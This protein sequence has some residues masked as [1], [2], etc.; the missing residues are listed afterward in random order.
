MDVEIERQIDAFGRTIDTRTSPPKAFA[1]SSDSF[2]FPTD[3]DP[4]IT[5]TGSNVDGGFIQ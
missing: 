4:T 5:M 2:V 3:V 1:M